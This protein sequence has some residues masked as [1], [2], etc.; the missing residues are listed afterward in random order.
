MHFLLELTEAYALNLRTDVFILFLLFIQNR[1][2]PLHYFKSNF[3]PFGYDSLR[4]CSFLYIDSTHFF[5]VLVLPASQVFLLF[6]L[7]VA[8]VAIVAIVNGT[9]FFPPF[10]NE[11]V[12]RQNLYHRFQR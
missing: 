8:V 3:I 10:K 5:L 2:K 12:E 9:F 4:F 6:F 1:G 7:I 11:P